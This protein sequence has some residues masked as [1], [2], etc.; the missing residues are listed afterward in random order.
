MAILQAINFNGKP[1]DH[2]I[3]SLKCNLVFEITGTSVNCSVERR[4]QSQYEISY[5]PTIKGRHQLHIKV[6]DQHVKGSPFK[7][8][9]K[10]SV[11]MLKDPILTISGLDVP[12]GVVINQRGEV[13]VTQSSQ[14]CVSLVCPNRNVH[15]FGT[16]GSGQGQ[17]KMPR[18]VVVDGEGDILVADFDRYCIQKYTA[19]G[20]FLTSVGTGGNEP[21]QFYSP[22]DIGFNVTNNKVYVVEWGNHR[23]QVLNSDLTFSGTFGEEGS[24]KGQF[25]SPC[26]ITCSGTGEVYVADTSNHRVQVF[27]ADGEY[28]RM[29]GMHG[30]GRGELSVPTGIAVDSGGHVYVSEGGNRRVSVFTTNGQF[31]TFFGDNGQLYHP[32]GLAV[33]E[34]GAVYVCDGGYY[35]CVK[36]F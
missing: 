24:G 27:T 3:A 15:S 16:L 11:L 6:E 9:V 20:Q 21:L 22:N 30:C 10:S 29:F 18:G 19:E 5:Q 13:V 36:V 4:G 32:R 31:M 1:C 2:K 23:I 14:P 26:G 12:W 28:L 7:V 8:L 17:F 33:D 34:S 25:S 35:C